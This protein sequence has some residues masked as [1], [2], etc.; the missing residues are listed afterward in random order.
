MAKTETPRRLLPSNRPTVT[1]LQA[2]DN[3]PPHLAKCCISTASFTPCCSMDPNQE[4]IEVIGTATT[5]YDYN[6]ANSIGD[7]YC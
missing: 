2:M 3:R 6:F 4:D 5:S 1:P 7:F